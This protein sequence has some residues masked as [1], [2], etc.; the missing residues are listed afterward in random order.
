M[1][2]RRVRRT[3]G[4][5]GSVAVVAVVMSGCGG[6]D[7]FDPSGSAEIGIHDQIFVELELD[8]EVDCAEPATTDVG[9]TFEC[10]ATDEEGKRYTFVAEILPDEVIGTRLA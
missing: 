9:A 8:S 3:W 5:V 6:E 4:R 7:P 2:I 1:S 10:I